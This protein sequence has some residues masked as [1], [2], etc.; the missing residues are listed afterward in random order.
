VTTARRTA[1]AASGALSGSYPDPAIGVPPLAGVAIW[2][3]FYKTPRGTTYGDLGWPLWTQGTAASASMVAISTETEIGVVRLSIAGGA[4][5]GDGAVLAMTGGTSPLATV[6]PKGAL[7]L[8]KIRIASGTQDFV[9]WS[10]FS[11]DPSTCPRAATSNH[12]IGL[13][14]DGSTGVP[15]WFGVVRQGTTEQTVDFGVTADSDWVILGFRRLFSGAIQ[16]VS[17]DPSVR[18]LSPIDDVG[19]PLSTPLPASAIVPVAAALMTRNSTARALDCDFLGLG[20]RLV[21]L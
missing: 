18:D 7:Y 19:D 6:P 12:F 15:N 20:G 14:A 4:N 11:S 13:R 2:E 17:A 3:E 10:G 9:A 21:R 1:G 8:V 16:F 5:D